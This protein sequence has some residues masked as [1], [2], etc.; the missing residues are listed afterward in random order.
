VSVVSMWHTLI[1][2]FGPL[3]VC[4]LRPA[5]LPEDLKRETHPHG[6]RFGEA[7]V[8]CPSGADTVGLGHAAYVDDAFM[9]SDDVRELPFRAAERKRGVH[10]G[11][12]GYRCR[13]A[14][15]TPH[16]RPAQK[17]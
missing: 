12:Y 17:R 8:V 1:R 16:Q 9:A 5:L 13:I 14:K 10:Q 7:T 4:A 15:C 11:K 2:S 3:N 6:E